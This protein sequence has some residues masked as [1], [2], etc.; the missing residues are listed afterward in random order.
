MATPKGSEYSLGLP[1]GLA[2]NGQTLLCQEICPGFARSHIATMELTS[3][4]CA[5]V[6]SGNGLEA[7][8][9]VRG[10]TCGSMP[11]MKGA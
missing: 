7:S 6:Q 11:E 4:R 1:T 3:Q 9:H 5:P 2:L 10:D 8:C